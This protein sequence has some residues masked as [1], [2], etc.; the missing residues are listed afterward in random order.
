MIRCI[1]C[2]EARSAE[3]GLHDSACLNEL[4]QISFVRQIRIDRKGGRIYAQSELSRTDR[5]SAKE[6]G[7]FDDIRVGSA[8]TAGDDA[9]LDLQFS[10]LYFVKQ[11]IRRSALGDLL[12]CLF[13]LSQT[14][15]KVRIELIDL[16]GVRRMER[17]RNHRFDR[18]KIDVDASVVI[19]Y[20][21]RV[22]FLIIL[23]SAV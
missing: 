2:A 5:L 8:R 20:I 17:E 6:I 22:E 19:C 11:R 7:G 10:V 23:R 9:L 4:A 14:V 16:N 12:R 13:R 3:C 21:R 1:A 15:F 18:G